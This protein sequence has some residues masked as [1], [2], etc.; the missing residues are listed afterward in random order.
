MPVYVYE[1][2]I[3]GEK[4]EV[5][6]SISLSGEAQAAVEQSLLG[7][8]DWRR[9]PQPFS[10]YWGDGSGA[11]CDPGRDDDRAM[12]RDLEKTVHAHQIQ[13]KGKP[14]DCRR[15][16]WQEAH[17]PKPKTGPNKKVIDILTGKT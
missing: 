3:T 8:G 9:I 1:N 6:M 13:T 7:A 5:E 11:M 15:D 4:R 16:D 2:R 14:N 17:T 10:V 12:L